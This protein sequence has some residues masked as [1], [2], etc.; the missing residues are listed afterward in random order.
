MCRC[1][2]LLSRVMCV[3]AWHTHSSVKPVELSRKHSW[4][5]WESGGSFGKSEMKKPFPLCSVSS[6][7]SPGSCFS[8]IPGHSQLSF[9]PSAG[10]ML[11]IDMDMDIDI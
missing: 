11:D 2:G 3:P 9:L 7:D 6:T 4:E 1:E 10:I 5:C 8:F